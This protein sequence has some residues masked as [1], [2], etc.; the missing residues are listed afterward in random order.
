VRSA[1]TT[2]EEELAVEKKVSSR[3]TLAVLGAIVFS[4]LV[5]ACGGGGDSEKQSASAGAGPV[6]EPTKP[7]TITFSSW[8]GTQKEMKQL[9]TQFH[10]EH[11][12]IT[13]KFQ[14]VP[15]EEASQKLTTQIAGG[16]PPDVAYLDASTVNDFASRQALVNLDTYLSRSKSVKADDY[17]PAFRTFNTFENHMFGLPIDGESTGLFYR[18]DLFKAAGIDKP[19][20]T[21]DEFSADAQKLT[22]PAKKQYGYIVFAPESAY[23]WYP[24]LWQQGGELLSKDGK[25][26]LFNSDTA[27]KAADYYIG[28]TKYSPKDFLNSNSYDGRVAFA[29]GKVAMYMAGDWFAGTLMGEYPKLTGKWAAAPLPQGSAGCKTTVAGDS[30]VVLAN[31]KNQDAAWKWIEFL[32]T[33]K[34]M[35]FWTFGSK[36]GTTLPPRT[37]LLESPELTQ[38]KPILKGFAD[39]M[40]CGV[41]NVIANPK[42]P[43]IEESLNEHLGK[44]MYGDQSPSEALDGAASDAKEILSR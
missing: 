20:T 19:P 21:W 23:Y 42:W 41:A 14:N 43:K 13:V 11:P 40:K 36:N 7:V 27:K 24:W 29:S 18:T 16:N 2:E 32:S 25:Q 17:V 5:A 4:V 3:T 34:N 33:P 1:R 9:A 31:S 22:N 26:V 10:A 38:K 6:P 37:S 8:V 30:L 12:N 28:L 39:Q 35:A 44:A 15:A